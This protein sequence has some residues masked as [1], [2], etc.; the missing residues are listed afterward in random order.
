MSRNGSFEISVEMVDR[1]LPSL[2]VNRGLSVPQGTTVI[3]GPECLALSDP[4]TPPEAL[5]FALTQPPQHGR[6]QLNGVALTSGSNF[7]QKNIQGI[8]VTY[9]HD[10][11]PS[12]IDRFGFT[13]SDSSSRG[14]LLDGRLQTA[15]VFFTIQVPVFFLEILSF[16]FHLNLN[17]H[18]ASSEFLQEQMTSLFSFKSKL[19]IQPLDTQ[20]PDVV[21]LLPLWK[22]EPLSDGRHG[23]FLSSHE[24]KAQDS[25]SRDE[26]LTFC[27]TRQ[28][29][30]GYLENVT[31]GWSPSKS[32]LPLGKKSISLL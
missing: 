25:G 9:K 27:I 14:F 10:G 7:T 2:S 30:F 13:A 32:G 15:A 1:I 29:Y 26:Q 19:Q 12:Q 22:A 11:G 5:T 23:I 3:L 31:T 6:L 28:P 16:H 18:S 17:K 21:K 24:L 20:A 4:D 8:E